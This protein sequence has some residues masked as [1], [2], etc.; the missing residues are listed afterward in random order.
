M[1]LR[2]RYFIFPE[3][4]KIPNTI[5]DP[6]EDVTETLH[7]EGAGDPEIEAVISET[8]DRN[9]GS[10][11]AV[12]V[13]AVVDSLAKSESSYSGLTSVPEHDNMT[14]A[15]SP[16]AIPSESSTRSKDSG[17]EVI[18]RDTPV[19]STDGSK[20]FPGTEPV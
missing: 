14:S 13:S 16:S 6:R 9:R 20:T 17:M 18:N 19:V 7:C 5:E 4:P 15:P 12:I 1:C 8:D 3:V 2:N 11:A 10:A